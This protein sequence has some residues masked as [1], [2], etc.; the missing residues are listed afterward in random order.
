MKNC[1]VLCFLF[2]LFNSCKEQ[3]NLVTEKAS[4]V[5]VPEGHWDNFQQH[6]LENTETD[7]HRKET[8]DKHRHLSLT[9]EADA[10]GT[11][12][13][14]IREGRNGKDLVDKTTWEAISATYEVF[15]IDADTLWIQGNE[16]FSN[17][18][19]YRFIRTRK[20]SGWIELPLEQF[21]DSIYRKGNLTIHDQGGMAEID[22]HGQQYTAE[23]TQLLFGQ[24]LA[25]M[26]LAIYDM[27]IDS[28]GI[29]SRSISY[30]WLN[31][32]AKRTGINLRKVTSGWTYIEPGYVNS[33]NT[34]FKKN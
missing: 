29:N 24:K 26:K 3:T 11:T 19:P 33:D 13:V 14:E 28:V 7:M 27:P 10:S 8:N 6:W 17:E 4:D 30:T 21:G 9:I 22:I 31:P 5:A 18:D 23:L 16:P 32:E 2:A 12:N 34:K 15:K 20:F 1:L 25:I